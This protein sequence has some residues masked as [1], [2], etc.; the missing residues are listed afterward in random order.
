M[1]STIISDT[2]NRQFEELVLKL[3]L[4]LKFKRSVN[5]AVSSIEDVELWRRAARTAGRRLGIQVR[6]G[7]SR[8][9][10]VVWASEGP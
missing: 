1:K 6:T 5:Y 4:E 3:V 9:G 10:Q 2:D 8:D 7:I